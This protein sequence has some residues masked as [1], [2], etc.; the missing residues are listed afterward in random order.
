MM[1]TIEA[2]QGGTETIETCPDCD[3]ERVTS[4]LVALTAEGP[5]T[6]G[7]LINCDGCGARFAC[8]ACPR[9]VEFDGVAIHRHIASH[10]DVA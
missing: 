10:G 1:L 8:R 5:L 9:T 2:V 4:E 6:V 3:A 7:D